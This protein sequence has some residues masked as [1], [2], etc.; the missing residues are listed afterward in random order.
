MK[1][2]KN[3]KNI[4]INHPKFDL[5]KVRIQSFPSLILRLPPQ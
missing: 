5:K 3:A 4:Y 1:L 2:F